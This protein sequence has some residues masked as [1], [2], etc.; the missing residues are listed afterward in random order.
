MSEAKVLTNEVLKAEMTDAMVYRGLAVDFNT[1]LTSG[2][3]RVSEAENSVNMPS[4]AYGYGVLEVVAT[5]H[6]I[7]QR[8]ITHRNGQYTRMSYMGNWSAWVKISPSTTN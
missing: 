4:G 5:A 8:F 2:Y 7:L 6:F 1:I 3:Y